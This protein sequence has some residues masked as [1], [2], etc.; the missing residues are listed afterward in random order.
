MT[1]HTEAL[2]D[3]TGVAR[4]LGCS[5]STVRR[6]EANG[7]LPPGVRLDSSNR[8]VWRL[9]QIEGID[10]GATVPANREAAAPAA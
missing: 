8:R 3:I 5:P 6:L 9:A 10:R 4:R 2:L 7:T 1:R